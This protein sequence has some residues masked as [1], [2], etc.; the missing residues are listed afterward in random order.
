[1]VEEIDGPYCL[2][3]DVQSIFEEN[4]ELRNKMDIVNGIID[5]VINMVKEL[6]I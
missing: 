3:S 6:K 4:I 2:V 5:D 1:M